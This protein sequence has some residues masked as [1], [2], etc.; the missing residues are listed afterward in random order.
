[1]TL[2]RTAAKTIVSVELDE[3]VV[4]SSHMSE[5][6][7]APT[8]AGQ[9]VTAP[10][11]G[12]GRRK[13]AVTRVRLVPSSGKRTVNGR[14]PEDYFSDKL[15]Q[16]LVKLPFVLLDIGGCFS[17]IV[18]INGSGISGQTGAL[19][20]GV[21]RALSEI[22]RGTNHLALKGV[23]FLTRDA[24]ATECKKAGPKGV[25]KASQFPKR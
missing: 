1:M 23:D 11:A 22:D 18:R 17:V 14:T 20:F 12:L 6:E 3:E 25:H 8:G 4:P 24:R 9:S 10:G 21:S 2:R 16:Q 15:H 19:R 13:E 7:L 5:T